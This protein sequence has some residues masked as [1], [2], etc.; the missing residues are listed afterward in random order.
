M[1]P[2]GLYIGTLAESSEQYY[3]RFLVYEIGT[4]KKVSELGRLDNINKN[5]VK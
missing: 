3:S 5:A 4:G 2:S 1:D